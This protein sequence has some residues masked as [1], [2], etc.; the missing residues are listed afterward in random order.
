MSIIKQISSSIKTKKMSLEDKITYLEK[1]YKKGTKISELPSNYVSEDGIIVNNVIINIKKY[2]FKKLMTIEQVIKC[3]NIGINFQDKEVTADFKI[4]FL[5]KAIEEGYNLVYI[6]QNHDK[7]INNSIYKFIE[8]L[9]NNYEQEDL[10]DSQTDK[11]INTL[12]I[13]IPK[14]QRKEL[15]LNIIRECALKNITSYN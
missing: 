15:A 5:M 2:Y 6:I 4:D 7:Y 9:R 1:L 8:D 12:S 3:E 14:D 10:N 13:I 11:C